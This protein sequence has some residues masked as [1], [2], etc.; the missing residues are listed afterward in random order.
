[1]G[2]GIIPRGSAASFAHGPTMVDVCDA[3]SA[4]EDAIVEA[5]E[6][7]S[8]TFRKQ[9]GTCKTLTEQFS[10]HCRISSLKPQDFSRL[11]GSL[12]RKYGPTRLANEIVRV[13]SVF[14][15]AFENELIDKPAR[16]G[17]QFNVPPKRHRRA[18]MHERKRDAEPLNSM[19]LRKRPFGSSGGRF[20]RSR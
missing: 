12:A 16:Y 18:H 17:R 3:Y 1:V 10:P 20:H 19:E 5:G 15:H 8:R 2:S 13:R 4:S 7:S 11:S 6:L 14:K 9:E